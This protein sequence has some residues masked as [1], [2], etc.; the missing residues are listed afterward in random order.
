MPLPEKKIDENRRKIA[1]VA[2]H[3]KPRNRD[4]F[5]DVDRK[6]T[7]S[8][9]KRAKDYERKYV[10]CRPRFRLIDFWLGKE[11]QDQDNWNR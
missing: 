8:H 11:Y 9:S 2:E 6:E 1:H 7:S 5:P 4:L 10:K 3:H